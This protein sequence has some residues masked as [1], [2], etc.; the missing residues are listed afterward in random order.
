MTAASA[1]EPTGPP[2]KD[3]ELSH[4]RADG[5]SHMVDVSEKPITAREASASSTLR[6]RPD[7]IAKILAGDLPK[8]EAISVARIAGIMAAKRTS[9]LVPM[10]HPLPISSVT[11]EIERSG[12][13]EITATARVR[14]TG[15]TG[16]EMEALTAASVAA[17]TLFDMIKAVDHL[18]VITNTRVLAKSGGKSGDWSREEHSGEQSRSEQFRGEQGSEVGHG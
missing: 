2:P 9:D 5:S 4:V 14:T 13:A 6:T 16:V 3:G 11:V 10:C 7:V 15:R 12:E 1:P 17:L 8:G 18:A